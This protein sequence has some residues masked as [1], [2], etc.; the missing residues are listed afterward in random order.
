MA[1]HPPGRRLRGR[2]VTSL[3]LARSRWQEADRVKDAFNAQVVKRREKW[4]KAPAGKE[5][6]KARRDLAEAIV[7][8]S[9]AGTQERTAWR[10]WH[11]LGR[12][13]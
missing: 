5:A 2:R 9:A 4:R 7:Q 8:L 12:D 1:G 11:A 13:G 10:T 6:D 3:E